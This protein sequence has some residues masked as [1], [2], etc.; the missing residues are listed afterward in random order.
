MSG[1]EQVATAVK[2]ASSVALA[3]L[4][5]VFLSTM[6][7]TT[8]GIATAAFF[9]GTA[10]TLAVE[11]IDK[12]SESFQSV[13]VTGTH[14]KYLELKEK[15]VEDLGK[16]Y[17]ELTGKTYETALSD[18]SRATLKKATGFDDVRS[19]TKLMAE[20]LMDKGAYESQRKGVD[21]FQ[22][23]YDKYSSN[24]GDSRAKRNLNAS[25]EDLMDPTYNKFLVK[26]YAPAYLEFAFSLYKLSNPEDK[27]HSIRQ[28]GHFLENSFYSLTPRATQG[29][30]Y[31]NLDIPIFKFTVVE[32][33]KDD[34]LTMKDMCSSRDGSF[35]TPLSMVDS[36]SD[37]FQLQNEELEALAKIKADEEAAATEET[38]ETKETEETKPP[39]VIDEAEEVEETAVED[40]SKPDSTE[41][42]VDV[43]GS[44]GEESE[45]EESEGPDGEVA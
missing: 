24:E 19:M 31:S 9:V 25:M 44:E 18:E 42:V 28:K 3:A 29:V 22:Y 26:N 2:V 36:L 10:V 20:A 43:S 23:M 37:T 45:G 40:G 6:G 1:W 32:G 15:S 7:L 27:A 12:I 21:D 11:A 33:R 17:E 13:H 4:G 30:D 34:F 41:V 16:L 14:R 8:M 35:C 38:A 5:V 39:A